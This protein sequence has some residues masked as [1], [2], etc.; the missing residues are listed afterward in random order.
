MAGR[1]AARGQDRGPPGLGISASGLAPDPHRHGPFLADSLRRRRRGRQHD[2]KALQDRAQAFPPRKATGE[3]ALIPAA[4]GPARDGAA[5]GAAG[6]RT[7]P[8]QIAIKSGRPKSSNSP[9]LRARGNQAKPQ[10]SGALRP[11]PAS[12]PL[13]VREVANEIIAGACRRASGAGGIATRPMRS[14]GSVL[15]VTSRLGRRGSEG[16]RSIRGNEILRPGGLSRSA[17]RCTSS[18]MT[19]TRSRRCAAMSRSWASRIA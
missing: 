18:R 14:R 16:R 12:R 4:T 3:T 2:L 8:R 15:D 6:D 13:P 7:T 19:G 11:T 1:C 17:A 5:A 9:S 10:G